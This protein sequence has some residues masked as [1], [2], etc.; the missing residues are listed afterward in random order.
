MDYSKNKWIY[1]MV[2]IE[3]FRWKL[4]KK[5]KRIQ[6]R[7]SCKAAI[8]SAEPKTLLLLSILAPLSN[9]AMSDTVWPRAEAACN[10]VKP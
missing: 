1:L 6:E 10:A 4:R 9:R 8:A 7:F 5:R 3:W 2:M